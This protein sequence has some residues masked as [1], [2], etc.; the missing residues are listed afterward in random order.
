MNKQDEFKSIT[1]FNFDDFIRLY[2]SGI[3]TIESTK[4]DITI[5]ILKTMLHEHSVQDLI[6][7][8]ILDEMYN[9]KRREKG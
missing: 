4:P 1:G 9:E 7:K 6:N 5:K 2:V 3:I 8:V